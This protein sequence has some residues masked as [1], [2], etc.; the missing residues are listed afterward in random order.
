MR[1]RQTNQ[2]VALRLKSHKVTPAD[3]RAAGGISPEDQA[4]RAHARTTSKCT[5]MQRTAEA[6][7]PPPHQVVSNAVTDGMR[8]KTAP[9]SAALRQDKYVGGA[10]LKDT[11]PT[12]NVP[13]DN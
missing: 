6:M 4:E 13:L 2:P 3:E 12:N 5:E 1:Y 11:T 10:I 7:K 8:N 9:F